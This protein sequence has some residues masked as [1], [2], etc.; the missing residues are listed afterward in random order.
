MN[1]QAA[2]AAFVLSSSV[3]EIDT[4]NGEN[5]GCDVEIGGGPRDPRGCAPA[6]D[7]GTEPRGEAERAVRPS[8]SQARTGLG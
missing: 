5:L 1:C 2:E 7:G 4:T 8:G 3:E 6:G